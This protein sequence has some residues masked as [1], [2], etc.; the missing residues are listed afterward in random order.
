MKISLIL[1]IALAIAFF[2]GNLFLVLTASPR[3]LRVFGTEPVA[4]SV[5]PAR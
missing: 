3:T 2:A 4:S 1:C 5:M